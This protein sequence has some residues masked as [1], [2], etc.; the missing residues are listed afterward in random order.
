MPFIS[1]K[2]FAGLIPTLQ[3]PMINI[4]VDIMLIVYTS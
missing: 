1:K 3:G 4:Y 2:L